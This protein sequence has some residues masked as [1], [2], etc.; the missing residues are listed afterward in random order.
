[1]SKFKVGD[2][3]AYR[4]SDDPVI[5][6]IGYVLGLYRKS[7]N[8]VFYWVREIVDAESGHLVDSNNLHYYDFNTVDSQYVMPLSDLG[9]SESESW[10]KEHM[11]M[12]CSVFGRDVSKNTCIM[13]DKQE[14]LGTD[15]FDT[16]LPC[17]W[18]KCVSVSCC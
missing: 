12:I 4:I 17:D 6:S 2:I 1:M 5:C 16:Y 7:E 10:C 11:S 8:H 15:G 14:Q 3:I 13:Y 9:S 18:I